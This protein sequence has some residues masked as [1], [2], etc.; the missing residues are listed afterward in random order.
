MTQTAMVGR[1]I[2][3]MTRLRSFNVKRKGQ[4]GGKCEQIAETSELYLHPCHYTFN[5]CQSPWA[6]VQ[7]NMT[8]AYGEWGTK[9]S[10]APSLNFLLSR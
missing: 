4:N 2:A 3:G 6:A 7:R 1:I 9:F 8:G 10:L 5:C